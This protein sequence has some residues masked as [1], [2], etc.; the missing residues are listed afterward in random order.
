[1]VNEN[2]QDSAFLSYQMGTDPPEPRIWERQVVPDPSEKE[3]EKSE[4]GHLDAAGY[5]QLSLKILCKCQELLHGH[6]KGI[7]RRQ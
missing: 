2:V 3:S 5:T 6:H 4:L 7:E 1:M